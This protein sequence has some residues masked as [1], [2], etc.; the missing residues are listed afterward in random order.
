MLAG[1]LLRSAGW[2]I[3]IFERSTHKMWGTWKRHNFTT[4]VVKST[5]RNRL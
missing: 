2:E 4:S 3:D 5:S 1:N